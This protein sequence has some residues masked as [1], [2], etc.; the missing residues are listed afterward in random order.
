[1]ALTTDYWTSRATQS[2]MTII[3]HFIKCAPVTSAVRSAL[4]DRYPLLLL[5]IFLQWVFNWLVKPVIAAV[6]YLLFAII[7]IMS[8]MGQGTQ[9]G[10]TSRPACQAGEYWAAVEDGMLTH[11]SPV[12]LWE[13]PFV[14]IV[15]TCFLPGFYMCMIWDLLNR[16]I[17]FILFLGL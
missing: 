4:D 14:H 15:Q 5:F 3:A 17:N 6:I 12:G 2:Y 8:L 7:V 10:E 11:H 1:M 13:T 16:N 9:E